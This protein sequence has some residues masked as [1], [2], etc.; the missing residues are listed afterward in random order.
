M[1]TP[2]DSLGVRAAL[3]ALARGFD[4]EAV[5]IR[6]GGTI[7]VVEVMQ[8]VLGTTPLLMGFGLPEDRAHAPNERFGLAN[9]NGGIRA[10]AA[11]WAGL[12]R[13]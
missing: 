5:F 6:E 8:R 9:L 3:R 4:R 10:S 7:P 12:A 13:A 1:L 11:L 2:T